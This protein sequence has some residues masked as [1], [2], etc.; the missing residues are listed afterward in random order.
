MKS[1]LA[2]V[3]HPILGKPILGHV[4]DAV[5]ETQPHQV[6]VVVGHQRDQV[7]DYLEGSYPSVVTAVQDEQNG[8]GHAVRCAFDGLAQAGLAAPDGPIVVL[9]GDAPLLTG[10]TL[11]TL[12]TAHEQHRAAVTVL[13][14][15]LDDPFG[16]GRI[17]RDSTGAVRQIVEQ[18]D[19]TSE[20]QQIREISS[21]M[22]V[23][24]SETLI[25]GLSRLTTN[26]AQGE[27]Y[28]TDVL[29]MAC[30]EG[31][32]VSAYL[33]D[34]PDEVHGINN[35]VQLAAATAML[36]DR[37]NTAYMTA[38]VAIVDPSTTWIE[39]GAVIA[40]DA[41]IERNTSIDS[42]SV[43]EADA[44]IGPDTSLIATT[45]GCGAVVLKSHCSGAVINSEASV[46]PY[47]YL[48]P[49]TEL[50]SHGKIGAYVEVKKSTIGA[51]SKVPHLSYVGDATIGEGTNIGAAT[52]FANYDGENKHATVVG[53]NV[54]VGSDSILVAP[55][56][57]GDGAYTAAGS[58][59]TQDVPA[60]AIG[61]GRERQ[62][63]V[64]GWVER[65]RPGSDSAQ[66]AA[67]HRT[68]GN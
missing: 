9:A 16:Y 51:H 22:F 5:L 37:I 61:I 56:S 57:I 46:G 24:D 60:G 19:A 34:D 30:D 14:A 67:R 3:L 2:K 33:T 8:T 55:V 47:S 29:A 4:L 38:G 49:G 26:N 28:L 43:V 18:K 64:D 6:V 1:K 53:D 40:A 68:D 58:V 25:S 32:N 54:R 7:Q 41:V 17:V 65:S 12:V 66:S 35:R 45:V 10:D 31:K 44:V 23:F 52:I 21:G 48:R 13:S 42:Q 62:T 15:E 39:K 63:N 50:G 11:S 36:R 27:E 20:Q 59:I